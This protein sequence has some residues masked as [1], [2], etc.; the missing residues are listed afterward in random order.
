MSLWVHYNNPGYLISQ[1]LSS[2]VGAGWKD[3]LPLS[4]VFLISTPKKETIHVVISN[5][6]TQ[7]QYNAVT[8]S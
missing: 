3:S 7:N 6:L 2:P 5:I 8:T 4:A 1:H